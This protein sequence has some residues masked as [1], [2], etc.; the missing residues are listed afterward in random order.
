MSQIKI[1]PKQGLKVRKPDGSHLNDKG[2][3]VKRTA[4][5]LRRL[6][7]GDVTLV[8][9]SPKKTITKVI[10]ESRDGQS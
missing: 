9:V 10:K 4:F 8:E 6:K 5:W 7:D 3:I 2:E 1:K